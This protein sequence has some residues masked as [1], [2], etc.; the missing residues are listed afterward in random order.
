MCFQKEQKFTI[1]R[2]LSGT[3][4]ILSHLS[5][6]GGAQLSPLYVEYWIAGVRWESVTPNC[7]GLCLH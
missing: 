6:G 2:F 5:R 1:L 7:A 4:A 3:V